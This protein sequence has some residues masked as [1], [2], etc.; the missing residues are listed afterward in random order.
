MPN[1]EF[2]PASQ[3]DAVAIKHL[4][5]QA[6]LPSE[7]FAAHLTHFRLAKNDGELAG[8]IGLEPFGEAGLLRSLVAAPAYRGQGLGQALVE[9]VT[10]Y[11]RSLGVREL[12]LLTT[13]AADFFPRLGFRVIDRASVPPAIQ[14]TAEFAS[15]CPSTAVCMSK[16]IV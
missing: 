5:A 15:I 14:T 11:A 2:G 1:F 4:L 10:G 13:T 8:V 7:D 16:R 9:Q 12:Y 3:A 6:D